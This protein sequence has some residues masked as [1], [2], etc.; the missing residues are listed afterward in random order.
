[1]TPKDFSTACVLPCLQ[2][3]QALSQE[4][5][6]IVCSPA[7]GDDGYLVTLPQIACTANCQKDA[8]VL[9]QLSQFLPGDALVVYLRRLRNGQD[10]LSEQLPNHGLLDRRQLGAHTS[11][12]VRRAVRWGTSSDSKQVEM[13]GH[14]AARLPTLRDRNRAAL[15]AAHVRAVRARVR[16]FGR[17]TSLLFPRG[18]AVLI[19]KRGH[20]LRRAHSAPSIVAHAPPRQSRGRGRPPRCFRQQRAHHQQRA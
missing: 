18:P 2:A 10:G 8:R 9:L 11:H 12:A 20:V 17:S 6:T 16:A 4:A 5:Q 3:L 7:Q 19:A 15:S 14:R 1:M 13:R